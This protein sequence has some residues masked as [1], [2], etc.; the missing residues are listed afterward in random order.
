MSAI[1]EFSGEGKVKRART[2]AIR[3][4][5]LPA[6]TA[7]WAEHQETAEVRPCAGPNGEVGYDR[8]LPIDVIAHF[9]AEEPDIEFDRIAVLVE[10]ALGSA[11]KLDG[12]VVELTLSE[13]RSFVD[14]STGFALGVGALTFVADYKTVATD[15][16]FEAS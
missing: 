7:T 2:S 4:S 10:T 8:R 9:Q 15:P 6:L 13:T 1:R 16:E 14:R 11:I 12:L 3:E 5:M